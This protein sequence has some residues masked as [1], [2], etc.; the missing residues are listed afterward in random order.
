MK[1]NLD[2]QSEIYKTETPT[3]KSVYSQR[4]IKILLVKLMNLLVEEEGLTFIEEYLS[5]FHL[6]MALFVGEYISSVM[7]RISRSTLV[8]R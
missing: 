2:F 3:L 5:T 8:D 7:C 6:V 1:G 4:E